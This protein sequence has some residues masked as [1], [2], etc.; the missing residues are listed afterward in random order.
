[1]RLFA[2]QLKKQLNPPIP[3]T[4]YDERYTSVIAQQTIITAGIKKK[5]RQNKALTDEVSATI[6]LQ[7]Y[8]NSTQNINRNK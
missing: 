5:A 1:M 8:L 6:I 3:I 7:D 4:F 2:E